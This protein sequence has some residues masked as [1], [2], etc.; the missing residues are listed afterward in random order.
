MAC[1][2]SVSVCSEHT[3]VIL[4][5][6]HSD[7]CT[8]MTYLCP[9]CRPETHIKLHCTIVSG[10]QFARPGTCYPPALWLVGVS[11]ILAGITDT[12]TSL[13]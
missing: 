4:F 9:V 10:C 12:R 3:A 11:L 1:A 13:L 2:M 8:D 7:R 6:G 5:S